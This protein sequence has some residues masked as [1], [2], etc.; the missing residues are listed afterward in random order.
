MEYI[1]TFSEIL[2]DGRTNRQTG[3]ITLD[4]LDKPLECKIRRNLNLI[5]Q[6]WHN[7][8]TRNYSSKHSMHIRATK[9]KTTYDGISLMCWVIDFW[10]HCLM[11]RWETFSF[12]HFLQWFSSL[13]QPYNNCQTFC[14][15]VK[16]Y[17]KWMLKQSGEMFY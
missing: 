3:V 16:C 6:P 10:R 14:I 17:L 8:G 11:E 12:S 7:H 15:S 2:K 1:W 13:L 9:P 5:N 4:P